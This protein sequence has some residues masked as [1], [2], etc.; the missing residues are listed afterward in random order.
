MNKD[1]MKT[2]LALYDENVRDRD[3]KVNIDR[4]GI[5]TGIFIPNHCREKDWMKCAELAQD[6]AKAM[7]GKNKIRIYHEFYADYIKE[8]SERVMP[9]DGSSK[10][11]RDYESPQKEKGIMGYARSLL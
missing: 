10:Y 5:S 2:M 9:G 11:F 7:E 6:A 1:A 4:V 8:E 3:I